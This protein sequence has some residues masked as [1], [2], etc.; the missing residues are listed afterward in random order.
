MHK[1]KY[2]AG[3]RVA[4]LSPSPNMP[5]GPFEIVRSLPSDRGEKLYR[6]RSDREPFERV[7]YERQI[8]LAATSPKSAADAVFALAI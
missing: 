6:V 1:H 5:V 7:V 4:I 3:D 2:A 8:S